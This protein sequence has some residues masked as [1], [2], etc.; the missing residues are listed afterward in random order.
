VVG[1]GAVGMGKDL[2]AFFFVVNSLC[3]I[4]HDK[5]KFVDKFGN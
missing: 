3:G 5:L 4:V 1:G 2:R